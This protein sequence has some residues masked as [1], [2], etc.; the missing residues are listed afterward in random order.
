MDQINGVLSGLPILS[1]GKFVV[2]IASFILAIIIYNAIL[3]ISG[4]NVERKNNPDSSTMVTDLVFFVVIM[5]INYIGLN[6]LVIKYPFI[7]PF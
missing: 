5:V 1:E 4:L 2:F 3:R 7:L 6:I